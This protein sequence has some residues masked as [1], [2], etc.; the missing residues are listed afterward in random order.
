MKKIISKEAFLQGLVLADY[1]SGEHVNSQEF[2]D[3]EKWLEDIHFQQENDAE[4]L[5]MYFPDHLF[6]EPDEDDVAEFF[7]FS[8][9]DPSLRLQKYK[10][11]KNISSEER[12]KYREYFINCA[13]ENGDYPTVVIS[14]ISDGEKSIF[15]F[16]TV[17]GYSFEG[18]ETEDLGVFSTIEIGK[19][20]LFLDGEFIG[21]PG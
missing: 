15:Y 19:N 8:L 12:K 3:F 20:N 4:F 21:D 16:G 2:L 6:D 11:D 14:E 5:G 17:K 9:E 13:F 18:L 7:E 10:F 1:H